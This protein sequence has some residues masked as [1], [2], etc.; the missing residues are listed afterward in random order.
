MNQNYTPQKMDSN[1][2]RS[3]RVQVLDHTI[4]LNEKHS[5]VLQLPDSI[6]DLDLTGNLQT[7]AFM[8][9]E[10]LPD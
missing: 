7:L 1:I 9:V 8:R 3:F 5:K 2:S 4:I 6:L 10:N